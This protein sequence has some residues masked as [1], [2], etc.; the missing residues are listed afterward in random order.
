MLKTLRPP[1]KFEREKRRA[2]RHTVAL[3]GVVRLA[4]GQICVCEVHDISQSGAMLFLAVLE[5]LPDEFV[6]EIPGNAKVLRRC[7]LVRQE[8]T[9]IG[10][11]F[12]D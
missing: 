9:T 2:A 5:K 4:D 6:L 11:R 7:Q 8:G 10:V 3:E 1:P 12:P